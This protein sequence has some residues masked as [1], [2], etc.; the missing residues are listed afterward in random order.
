MKN[1]TRLRTWI[2]F[3]ILPVISALLVI[4]PISSTASISN[5]MQK[6]FN[7][8]SFRAT[9]TDAG[10]YRSQS[11]GIATG[12]SLSLRTMNS[13]NPPMWSIKPPYIKAGCGG[14]DIFFGAF[15]FIDP[16]EFVDMLK[17]IGAS[18]IGYAFKLGLEAVCPTC[19]QVLSDLANFANQ[20]ASI[21]Q[22]SC[23]T[24]A[25]LASMLLGDPVTSA[26]KSR[27]DCVNQKR[28]EEGMSETEARKACSNFL[29]NLAREGR[30]FTQ[31]LRNNS[32]D[33]LPNLAVPGSTVETALSPL[34]G[35]DEETK[36]VIR[37]ITGDIVLIADPNAGSDGGS[38]LKHQ[39]FEPTIKLTD[40]MYGNSDAD[41]LVYDAN[42]YK[43]SKE[44]R[45]YL[46]QGF[47]VKVR[48]LLNQ[49]AA[50]IKSG[51][52]LTTEQKQ[53]IEIC[54]F[55]VLNLLQSV[56]KVPSMEQAT[57]E[58]ISDSIAIM[59]AYTLANYYISHVLSNI[60]N[61]PH[62]DMK[63]ALEQFSKVKNEMREELLKEMQVLQ[64]QYTALTLATYYTK[65]VNQYVHAVLSGEPKK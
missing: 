49:I 38:A 63:T 56:S 43:M 65:T 18:A 40:L 46:D 61:Q 15:Q 50:Q 30:E 24:G 64:S 57:I 27:E 52:S 5:D 41:F 35:M 11:V 58:V 32:L 62:V 28:Q 4:S 60:N 36:I 13:F 19:N 2:N 33:R 23:Q 25:M 44:K 10:I 12:G 48:D 31:K 42:L 7:D 39:W 55:P 54:P 1:F 17:N 6:V 20:L 26:Q 34:A 9:M 51:T 16:Q 22:N 53:F 21:G 59:Y 29:E 37:S 3:F 45:G 14:I 47:K 8:L